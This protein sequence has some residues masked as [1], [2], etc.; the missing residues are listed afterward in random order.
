MLHLTDMSMWLISF[1][2][3][4]LF[5]QFSYLEASNFFPPES[6]HFEG[7]LKSWRPEAWWT[8]SPERSMTGPRCFAAS[9]PG[10]QRPRVD[11]AE[12]GCSLVPQRQ[13]HGVVI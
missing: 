3:L 12:N 11:G 2:Y 10:V 9:G 4:L 5:L 8:L 13:L 1:K 6:K 7:L